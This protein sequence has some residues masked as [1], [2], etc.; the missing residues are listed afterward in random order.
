ML[1]AGRN[2]DLIPI[3]FESVTAELCQTCYKQIGGR[4]GGEGGGVERR[5]GPIQVMK[6]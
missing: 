1:L 6:L 5:T 2:G 3:L 4:G